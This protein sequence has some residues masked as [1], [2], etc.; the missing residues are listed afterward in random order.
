MRLAPITVKVADLPDVMAEL[1]RLHA[2]I[3][4]LTA[5][6]DELE[7]RYEWLLGEI[8]GT[9][10]DAQRP[11]DGRRLQ[12]ETDATVESLRAKPAPQEKTT[13]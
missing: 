9:A 13:P 2:A 3:A 1:E 6:R 4:E 12:A 5:E 8:G 11:D 7:E 10:P